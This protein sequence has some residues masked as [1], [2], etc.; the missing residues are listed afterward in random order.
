METTKGTDTTKDIMQEWELEVLEDMQR[1]L[2]TTGELVEGWEHRKQ[3]LIHQRNTIEGELRMINKKIEEQQ[4]Y[5]L[6]LLEDKAEHLS[7][8]LSSNL[9]KLREQKGDFYDKF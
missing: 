5:S 2:R 7:N 1:V 4:A 9:D 8:Q 3:T 6:S